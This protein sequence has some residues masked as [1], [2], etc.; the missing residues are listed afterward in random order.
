MAQRAY[1][2]LAQR[3]LHPIIVGQQGIRDMIVVFSHGSPPAA[4][5]AAGFVKK[6][7]RASRS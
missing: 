2:H 4:A 1:G 6:F 7:Q 3:F 5:W